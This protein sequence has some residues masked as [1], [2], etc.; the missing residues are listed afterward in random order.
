MS[1]CQSYVSYFQGSINELIYVNE[2]KNVNGVTNAADIQYYCLYLCDHIN[3][4]VQVSDDNCLQRG[5]EYSEFADIYRPY[6]QSILSDNVNS[7][8]FFIK[9]IQ[10]LHISVLPDA[11]PCRQNETLKMER[12]IRNAVSNYQSSGKKAIYISG[13]PGMV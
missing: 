13:M 4:L 3:N 10:R 11:L 8:D 6:L 5:L 2:S 12:F 1:L 9:A 7:S